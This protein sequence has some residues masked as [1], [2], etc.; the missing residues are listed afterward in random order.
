MTTESNSTLEENLRQ[1]FKYFNR[2][3]L[4]LWRLGLGSWVNLWPEGGGQIMVLTHTGRK[5]GLRRQTPVNY[6]IVD[7]DIYCTAGFGHISDWYRNIRANPKVEIWLS[8]SWWAGTAEDISDDKNR[9]PLLRAVIIASGYAGIAAGLDAYNMS[10]DDFDQATRAYR[11]LRIRR[12]EART[13]PGG[14]GDLAW[15]W[16]LATFI[17]LPLVLF[18]RRR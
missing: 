8:D 15:I 6:A 2:F 10:D 13:G 4:L 7:G 16:P 3:M 1:G 5:S 14:P 17:L 9:I 12:T 18:R 11:L